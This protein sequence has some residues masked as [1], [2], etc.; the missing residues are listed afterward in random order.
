MRC[1][2]EPHQSAFRQLIWEI[3]RQHV[4]LERDE[5]HQLRA[6]REWG[7]SASRHLRPRRRAADIGE[8]PFLVVSGQDRRRG[9][10]IGDVGVKQRFAQGVN[11]LGRAVPLPSVKRSASLLVQSSRLT[12]YMRCPP[13]DSRREYASCPDISRSRRSTIFL[14]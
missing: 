14:L 7:V 11:L 12:R 5:A 9:G 4:R 2:S 1:S 8:Q 13:R 10:L 6:R 3:L